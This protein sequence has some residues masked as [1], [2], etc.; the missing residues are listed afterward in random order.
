MNPY[1]VLGVSETASQQE[2]RKAYLI[3]VKK[4]HPD[5]YGDNPL[6]ELAA[7]KLKEVNEAYEILSKHTNTNSG[8]QQG[9]SANRTYTNY[10][11]TQS[12]T[13]YSGEYANEF[14][15]VR[16]FLNSGNINAASQV[17]QSIPSHNA[18]WHYLM[19]IVLLR[20]GAYDAARDELRQAAEADPSNHEYAQAYNT[21]SNYGGGRYAGGY[22]NNCDPCSSLFCLPCFCPCC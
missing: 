9:T 16:Q 18:E 6:A 3:K 4:Y 19:G 15:R 8:T 5:Q 13:S 12:R 21:L 11:Q 22:Q 14:T 2:I 10:R 17:L 1:E 7:E 20:Q